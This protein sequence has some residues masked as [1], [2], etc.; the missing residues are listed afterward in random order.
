MT[1]VI[2]NYLKQYLIVKFNMKN[3]SNQSSEASMSVIDKHNTKETSNNNSFSSSSYNEKEEKQ[4]ID[5]KIL[6]NKVNNSTNS[7]FVHFN[8]NE[9]KKPQKKVNNA[10]F[11]EL[12]IAPN[13]FSICN[14]KEILKNC[15]A[16]ISNTMNHD[17]RNKLKHHNNKMYSNNVS[18]N[19]SKNPSENSLNVYDRHNSN[20]FNDDSKK[21]KKLLSPRTR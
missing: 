2:I 18:L 21:E 14:N 13:K 9:I 19:V 15:D 3:S 16:L 1:N 12:Y 11:S 5:K 17:Y 20:R 4:Q 7:T 6:K 8:G 10:C